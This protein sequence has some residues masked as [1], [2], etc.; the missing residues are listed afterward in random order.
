VKIRVLIAADDAA[1]IL[2][3]TT[4]GLDEYVYEQFTRIP[5]PMPPKELDELTARELDILEL[6]AD[7]LSNAAIGRQLF[8]KR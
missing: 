1:R 5:R 2:I 6:I 8:E 7:G 3:L 4:F